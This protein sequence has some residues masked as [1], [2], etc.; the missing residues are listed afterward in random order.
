MLVLVFIHPSESET[1]NDKMDKTN[2]VN[3]TFVIGK[4]LR[5]IINSRVILSL[6]PTR[7][8]TDTLI[9]IFKQG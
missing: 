4:L 5:I 3:C 7:C 6:H 2:G 1:G 8:Y 9:T